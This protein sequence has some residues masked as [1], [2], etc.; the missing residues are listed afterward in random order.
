MIHFNTKTLHQYQIFD[1]NQFHNFQQESL[2]L[3]NFGKSIQT[4][5]TK[6]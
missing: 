4:Q 2:K 6:L 5:S 1:L 3:Q